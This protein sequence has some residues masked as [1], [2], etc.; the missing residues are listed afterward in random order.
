[1]EA[2]KLFIIISERI[3]WMQLQ[4]NSKDRLRALLLRESMVEIR[5]K[6]LT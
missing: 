4:G 5:K 2:V 1:M 6:M 3:R